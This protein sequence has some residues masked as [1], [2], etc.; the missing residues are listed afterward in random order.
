MESRGQTEVM[1]FSVS[2]I[3]VLITALCAVVKKPLLSIGWTEGAFL[4]LQPGREFE[5]RR[6][7]SWLQPGT[8]EWPHYSPNS[9]PVCNTQ[10][11]KDYIMEA[12]PHCGP[13]IVVPFPLLPNAQHGAGAFRHAQSRARCS[14]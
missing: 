12:I 3:E 1:R 5:S 11:L 8:G 4:P 10:D 6:L 9:V 7:D 14:R 2:T 13:E